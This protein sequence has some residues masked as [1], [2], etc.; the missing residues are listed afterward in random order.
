VSQVSYIVL[1]VAL[2]GP[3]GTIGG[4]VH[5]VH[6]GLMKITLFFCAGNYAETLGV[7]RIS[8]MAGIGQRMPWTT[9][10]FTVGAL[11]MIG[12]PPVAGFISKWY[13]GLG[14]IEA[15]LGWVLAVLLFSSLL[16]AAYFLPIL[17]LA[18]F[19]A[20]PPSWPHEAHAD[21]ATHEAR[22]AYPPHAHPTVADDAA[23]PPRTGDAAL[24]L[25]L[26]T[27]CAAALALLA[28]LAAGVPLS[29]LD[30]VRFIATTEYLP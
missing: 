11:G 25:L 9:A 4:L 24:L 27:L 29:P 15:G 19:E 13:L 23:P 16:N 22:Q 10:A 18:W 8:Q 30:W 21:H 5:L 14:A 20:P 7:H 1:G 17:R 6:Q 12:V 28:G 3:A 2:F 26:P